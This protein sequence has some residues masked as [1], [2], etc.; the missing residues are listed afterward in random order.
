MAL[1]T[2]STVGATRQGAVG[3]LWRI[4]NQF[5]SAYKNGGQARTTRLVD[6]V[7]Q[8]QE[9]LGRA[10]EALAAL[11]HG[12]VEGFNGTGLVPHLPEGVSRTEF[13]ELIGRA[14]CCMDHIGRM[15]Q[16]TRTS[17]V[18]RARYY[19]GRIHADWAHRRLGQVASQ[20]LEMGMKPTVAGETFASVMGMVRGSAVG[21][22]LVIGA[23]SLL[24]SS[25]S[26][27]EGSGRQ[28]SSA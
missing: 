12:L 21:I 25:L 6:V 20:L 27:P 2:N 19:V 7:P 9:R 22:I 17:A 1:S 14:E 18:A 24:K 28:S 11:R 15:A 8:I 13:V 26:S 16:E 23:A 5:Q 4:I 10:R 3:E